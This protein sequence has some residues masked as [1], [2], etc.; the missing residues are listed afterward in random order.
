[1]YIQYVGFDNV[2][3]S[4]TYTFHVI[5]SSSE[6][7]EFTVKVQAEAFREDALKFQD[8]P[9]ICF[10]RLQ[11]ELDG[12]TPESRAEAHLGIGER[13]ILEY[14]A[15]HYPPKKTYGRDGNGA[16]RPLS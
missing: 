9:G 15:H 8:G 16:R 1:M 11:R 4:R 6:S 3:S 12:E 13:D 10:A 14:R 2:V 5:D 7:R